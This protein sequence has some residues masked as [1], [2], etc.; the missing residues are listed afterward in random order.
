M[1]LSLHSLSASQYF[2]VKWVGWARAEYGQ[3]AQCGLIRRVGVRVVCFS[4]SVVRFSVRSLSLSEC[5]SSP[6]TFLK[7]FCQFVVF[8]SVLIAIVFAMFCANQSMMN[9][10]LFCLCLHSVGHIVKYRK[11]SIEIIMCVCIVCS[12]VRLFVCLRRRLC[13]ALHFLLP[14]CWNVPCQ[15]RL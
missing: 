7:N 13:G 1:R 2:Y 6:P 10:L 12:F 11:L 15:A 5:W 4:P 8:C 14:F 9:L 3:S